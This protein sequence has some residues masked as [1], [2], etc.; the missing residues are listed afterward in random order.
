MKA[1]VRDVPLHSTGITNKYGG[2][3]MFTEEMEHMRGTVIE[4]MEVERLGL[5]H[6]K[7][8]KTSKSPEGDSKLFI[9]SWLDFRWDRPRVEYTNNSIRV[10]RRQ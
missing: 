9:S 7:V 3:F 10:L 1:R 8:Y 5:E 2:T 4:V 6:V